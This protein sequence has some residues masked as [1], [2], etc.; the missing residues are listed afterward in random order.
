MIEDDAGVPRILEVELIEP[1]LW[2]GEQPAAARALARE[3]AS[4]V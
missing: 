4:M 1:E 3:I 2:F